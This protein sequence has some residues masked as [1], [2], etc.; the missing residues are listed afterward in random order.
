MLEALVEAGASG[1]VIMLAGEADM[2]GARQLDALI[3]RQIAA[4]TCQLTIDVSGLRFADSAS[5]R[6]LAL[7]ARTLTERGGN[8]VLLDPQPSVAR[9]LAL[10]GVDQFVTIRRK[11]GTARQPEISEPEPGRTRKARDERGTG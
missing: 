10:L 3:A 4:G 5:I 7:A 8:L 6:V 11:A 9:V 1:P 2:T